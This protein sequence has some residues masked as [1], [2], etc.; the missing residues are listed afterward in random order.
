MMLQWRNIG[1]VSCFCQKD[2]TTWTQSF[3]WRKL[4]R[5]LPVPLRYV[6]SWKNKSSRSENEVKDKDNV[7]DKSSFSKSNYRKIPKKYNKFHENLQDESSFTKSD[8]IIGKMQ[9][10]YE[11]FNENFQDESSFSKSDYSNRKIPKKYDTF[12]ENFQ[13]ESSFTKS[14]NTTNKMHTNN[15]KF[16]EMN[17]NELKSKKKLLKVNTESGYVKYSHKVA[18]ADKNHMP[19]RVSE[20]VS[21]KVKSSDTVFKRHTNTR[22][23]RESWADTFGNLQSEADI[24]VFTEFADNASYEEDVKKEEKETSFYNHIRLSRYGRRHSPFWYGRRIME[25]EKAGKVKEAIEVFDKW[26]IEQDRVQPSSHEYSVLI[27]LLGRCGYTLKAFQLYKQMRERKIRVDPHIF[28]SLFNACTNSPWREDGLSRAK[29]LRQA[30][31]LSNYQPTYINYQAMIAAFGV[32]GDINTAF[33]IADEAARLRVT[34]NLLNSLL[35]AC[36]SDNTSGFRH[37]VLVW[38]KMLKMGVKPTIRSYNMLLRAVNEC[39]IGEAKTFLNGLSGESLPGVEHSNSLQRKGGKN[40]L[41]LPRNQEKEFQGIDAVLEK[42]EVPQ[43]SGV[44]NVEN[45][46]DV[47]ERLATGEL[48]DDENGFH[49]REPLVE[50]FDLDVQETSSTDLLENKE[51][52]ELDIFPVKS[53]LP[54]EFIS[55]SSHGMFANLPNILNPSDSDPIPDLDYRLVKGPRE[56][57]ALLGGV[58]GILNTLQKDGNSPNTT[59]FSLMSK[60]IPLNNNQENDLIAAMQLADVQPDTDFFNHLMREVVRKVPFEVRRSKAMELFSRMKSAGLEPNIRTY[61]ILA[62]VCF[63]QEQGRQFLEEI[64]EAGIM[65]NSHIFHNLLKAAHFRLRYKQFLMSKMEELGV[66]PTEISVQKKDKLERK[67]LKCSSTTTRVGVRGMWKRNQNIHG[68]RSEKPHQVKF[69]LCEKN[70]ELNAC[71]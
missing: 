25:L 40:L 58:A 34:D 10:K 35:M 4:E 54:S 8:H 61:G 26:M 48:S 62:H 42:Y 24:P 7:Q 14:D 19:S 31:I 44:G 36:I 38:R 17:L 5:C 23:T 11:K 64:M 53:S 70:M 39:G 37:A 28:T 6:S 33:S 43:V 22:N 52:W 21:E 1:R 32:C 9:K 15:D 65:A 51:W 2:N 55:Q 45:A 57:F 67:V 71:L 13:D 69:E 12:N 27:A 18:R 59:T 63:T 20:T 46:I 68:K 41:W 56:R 50:P 49:S 47:E 60:A 3:C 29:K 16:Q 30:M 66:R